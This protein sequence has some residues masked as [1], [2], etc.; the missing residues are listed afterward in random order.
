MARL[1][2]RGLLFFLAAL[3]AVVGMVALAGF[4]TSARSLLNPSNPTVKHADGKSRK[5]ASVRDAFVYLTY[6]GQEAREITITQGTRFNFDMYLKAGSNNDASAAQSYLGFSSSLLQVV[7]YDGIDCTPSYDLKPDPTYFDFN[8]Q[9]EVCNGPACNFRGMRVAPGSIAF[10]S[11]GLENCYSGCGGNFRVAQMAMCGIRPGRAVLHWQF[12]PPDPINRDCEVVSF[13]SELIQNPAL[14]HDV[15]VNVL[16]IGAPTPTATPCP[17]NF[18][19]VSP[20]DY[21][22]EDV[23]Y[24]YCQGAISGYADGTFRPSS[25]TTRAQIC[26]ILILANGWQI[27]TEGAP[28]FRDVDASNPFF[29]YIETAYNYSAIDGYGDSSF[30]P[31]NSV[32]RGQIS[33]IA[34]LAE[35]WPLLNPPGADFSD[36]P[37]G[38]AFFPYV[39]TAY[40]HGILSGYSDGTFRPSNNATRGQLS[41]IIHK[42]LFAPAPC[43]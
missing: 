15:I 24:L 31:G 34:S 37:A 26:K 7:V 16:P 12:Y 8:L 40:C 30:R 18:S 6:Q 9:N 3:L 27:N 2:L 14:Y 20:G 35:G 42:A 4:H 43:P 13:N 39:E 32:T 33:K 5:P 17:L 38:S 19:D 41:K 28:H 23:R 1:V 25:D 21:F 29:N 11:G 10:A 36:V 22:Y